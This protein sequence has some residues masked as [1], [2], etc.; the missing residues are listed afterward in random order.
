MER[1][2]INECWHQ[3]ITVCHNSSFTEFTPM[4]EKRCEDNSFVKTCKIH[5]KEVS[6]NYTVTTCHKPL[7]QKCD[8]HNTQGTPVTVCRTWFETVC[9]TTLVV[10]ADGTHK[11]GEQAWC[12]KIPKKICAPDHCAMVEGNFVAL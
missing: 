8:Y 6:L 7:V 9:N 10:E 12:E 3:N 5:F 4:Q 11:G 2:Q 1:Q